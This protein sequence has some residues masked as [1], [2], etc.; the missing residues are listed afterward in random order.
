MN[1]HSNEKTDSELM[2]Q[3]EWRGKQ[4]DYN[5]SWETYGQSKYDSRLGRSYLR[6][7]CELLTEEIA[8]HFSE[9]D[10]IEVLEVGCGT[11]KTL[12]YLCNKITNPIYGVDFS[13]GMLGAAKAS[14]EI[15]SNPPS[16]ML[17]NAFELPFEDNSFDAVYAT[18]FMHQ[19]SHEEKVRIGSEI[20]RVLRPG[21]LV[22]LEF[23]ARPIN[24]LNFYIPISRAHRYK[25]LSKHLIHYP[26]RQEEREIADTPYRTKA[27]RFYG[28]RVINRVFGYRVFSLFNKLVGS[29]PLLRIFMDEHWIVYSK[30]KEA[31]STDRNKLCE[32]QGF[33]KIRCPKCQSRLEGSE[34]V[35]VLIC[36]SCK[37]KF[38][39]TNG[40]PGMIYNEAKNLS[41]PNHQSSQI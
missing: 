33:E 29:N 16:L 35:A 34:E 18:R 6:R 4:A 40:I 30:T 31:S 3:A 23:Y 21:G 10:E 26:T 19:F 37:V 14:T 5:K 17:G 7:R 8:K 1:E 20:T 32:E 2:D 24:Y 27:L 15:S 9:E 13:I 38:P 11:G 12:E 41:A 39:V 36:N 25:P 22:L 28:D